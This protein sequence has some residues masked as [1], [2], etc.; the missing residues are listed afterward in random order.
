[1][2][3]VADI[4]R[5]AG[6]AYREAYGARLLPS[7]RRVMRDL[8]QCRTPARGGHVRRCDHCDA[9]H[10]HYHSCRNRH[11][12]KCHAEQTRR[13]LDAQRARLLPCA[14]YLLTFTLPAELRPLAR[15]HQKQVYAI[16]LRCAAAALLKLAA[17]PRFLGASPGILAVLHTWTRAM[18][19][20]PHAHLLVTAGGLAPDG[21][22]WVSPPRRRFLVPARA[23]SVIFRAKVRTALHR[24]GLLSAVPASLWRRPWVVHCQHAGRGKEVL[25]YLARYVFRV[26]IVNSRLE[27][28]ANGRVTFRYRDHR[29]GQTRRCT[30]TAEEFLRRFLQHVLPRRFTKVRSYAL[31]SPTATARLAHARALLDAERP[32]LPARAESA[33]APTARAPEAPPPDLCPLCQIGHLHVIQRL[34]RTR[35]PP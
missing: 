17:D 13:W 19:Y 35:G 26:A 6:P 23:L 22:R 32:S 34:P 33:A 14:Y 21:Q 3:E 28:F 2:L 15:S 20:H 5:Q 1:M 31:Y 29:S 12:P 7:H 11:C 9:L 25:A 10:Y 18:L 16:L 30:V 27:R 24:A 4:L 8:E